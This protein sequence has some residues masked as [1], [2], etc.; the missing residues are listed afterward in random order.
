MVGHEGIDDEWVKANAI[1]E[2]VPRFI[3]ATMKVQP[4]KVSSTTP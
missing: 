1:E 2:N 4:F 3:I